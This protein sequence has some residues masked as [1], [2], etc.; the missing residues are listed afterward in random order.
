MSTPLLSQAASALETGDL[1][2][3]QT[4][5]TQLLRQDARNEGAWLLLAQCVNDSDKQRTCLQRVL[6]LNPDN[7]EARQRL[8]ALEQPPLPETK[9]WPPFQPRPFSMSADS[10]P[11]TPQPFAL[12]DETD[13][14]NVPDP[15]T[16]PGP[17]P[18]WLRP[19]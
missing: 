1:A 18:P 4:L 7:T 3:A 9:S 10:R 11:F 6:A 17:L 8:T 14:Q 16:A 15:N 5:L 19:A 13:S 2:T 12:A